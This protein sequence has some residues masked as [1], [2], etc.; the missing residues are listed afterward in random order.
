M[1]GL[2][3][4][5]VIEYL[6][7]VIA[8]AIKRRRSRGWTT[9]KATV[10]SSACATTSSCDLAEVVYLYR[11]EGERY[12]GTNKKPFFSKH[13]AEDYIS[14]FVAGTEFDVRVKPDDPEVSIV[15]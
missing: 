13:S 14:H 6:I 2:Y 15:P 12:S 1:I 11:F 9:T 8:R 7:R 3:L 4:D 10:V 5:V